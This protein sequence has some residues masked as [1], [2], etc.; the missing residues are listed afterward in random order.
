MITKIKESIIELMSNLGYNVDDNGFYREEFPW[1]MLRI[2][3]QSES[4]TNDL[5]IQVIDFAIDIFS[6]YNGEKEI[7]EI[8][9]NI[10]K[11]ILDMGNSMPEVLFS[12]LKTFKVLDDKSTGP[13]RKHGVLVYRFLITFSSKEEN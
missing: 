2:S 13:I 7:F 1:L 6:A 11:P 12:Q 5:T 4:Y 8:K 9:D 10:T 3:N